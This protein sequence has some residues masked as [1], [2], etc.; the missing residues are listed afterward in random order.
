MAEIFEAAQ[1]VLVWLGK[2]DEFTK[3]AITTIE[4][5]ASI[6]EQHWPTI[7]YTSFYDPTSDQQGYRPNL[8]YHNW[9]GFM[10]LINRP[11]FKRAWGKRPFFTTLVKLISPF[12]LCKK[13]L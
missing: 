7:P 5:I 12:Q 13:L 2:E 3:D 1:N 4:R 6:P 10:T 8:S 9:L 11:W